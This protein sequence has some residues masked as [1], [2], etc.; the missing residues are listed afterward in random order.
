MSLLDII[1]CAPFRLP[2]PRKLTRFEVSVVGDALAQGYRAVGRPTP[3]PEIQ[4]LLGAIMQ[5]NS[6]PRWTTT[7]FGPAPAVSTYAYRCLASWYAPLDPLS[8][9][10]ALADI[11]TKGLLCAPNPPWASC[12]G[13]AGVAGQPQHLWE[14]A[15]QIGSPQPGDE[16][17][18]IPRGRIAYLPLTGKEML[19]L[20]ELVGG[21]LP[22]QLAQAKAAGS[23]FMDRSFLVGVQARPVTAAT[24]GNTADPLALARALTE[25]AALIWAPGKGAS[26]LFLLEQPI[27]GAKVN[28]L[29]QAMMPDL[30]PDLLGN[31]GNILPGLIPPP[32]DPIWGQLLGGLVPTVSQAAGAPVQ[33]GTPP[34]TGL[35]IVDQPGETLSEQ[36]PPGLKGESAGRWPWGV[37]AFLAS[38][39]LTYALAR[40]R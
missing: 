32:T 12:P 24:V 8:K 29:I 9:S 35:P 11:A 25:E 14:G 20:F 31:L 10:R 28:A 4:A 26:V 18:A 39:A 38:A 5:Q 36:P 1:H 17:C 40:M 30:L 33:P 19:E 2:A 13:A 3:F 37:A 27:D 23:A 21:S 15:P 7:A 22:P 34:T 16:P 6:C